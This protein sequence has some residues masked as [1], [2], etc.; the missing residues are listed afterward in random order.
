MVCRTNT[1]KTEAGIVLSRNYFGNTYFTIWFTSLQF[2]WQHKACKIWKACIS[3]CFKTRISN[4]RKFSIS[5]F[6]KYKEQKN[7]TGV[8]EHEGRADDTLQLDLTHKQFWEEQIAHVPFAVMSGDPIRV[9]RKVQYAQE[10]KSMK[11]FGLGG[12]RVG[13]GAFY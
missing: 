2:Q 3:D 1:E 9:K 4:D 13:I 11:Q 7:I 6:Y 10:L 5:V 12:C 8:Q